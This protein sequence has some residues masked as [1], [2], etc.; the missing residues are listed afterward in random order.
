[1]PINAHPEYMHAE[2]KFLAAQNDEERLV[3]LLEMIK[4]MPK[5]KSAEALRKNVRTRY[6]KLKQKLESEKKKKKAASKKLGIKKADMQAVLVGLTNSGKSSILSILTNAKP[7]IAPYEYTTKIPRLGI[8]NFEDTKIQIIDLPAIE[9][10]ICEIGIINTADVLLLVIDK[11]EQLKEIF[12]F[13]EKA[14]KNRILILNKSDLL[15]KNQKRKQ[16]AT[17]SS[18]FKQFPS[19]LFS[20]K[21][22][23]AEK[24]KELKE[25]IWKSF[26]KIRV[27]TKQPGK[28]QDK[29]P[30][31]L[32]ENSTVKDVAEKILHGFSSEIKETRISGPSSK[33][34]NQKTSLSHILKDKDIVEFHTK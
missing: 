29:E 1:M 33:F 5:H 32:S 11:I 13:L 7:K 12:P 9:N 17:L 30:I 6:K 22:M 18:K 26:H 23:S 2:K 34:T 27:Y 20:T 25:K 24:I 10:E 21:E 3:F 15:D 14:S 31:V 4:T 16:Q 8:L 28:P 19:I